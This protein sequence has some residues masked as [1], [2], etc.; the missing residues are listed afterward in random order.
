MTIEDGV[1]GAE[2]IKVGVR[3]LVRVSTFDIFVCCE[4]G[5]G[6]KSER[7]DAKLET[8]PSI[9]NSKRV[10]RYYIGRYLF[11]FIFKYAHI[12]VAI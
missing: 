4:I 12:K 8:L 6:Q 10:S 7:Y 2:W 3:S 1:S 11:Y 9:R 5:R